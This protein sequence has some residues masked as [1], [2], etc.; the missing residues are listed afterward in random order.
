[1]AQPATATLFVQ[2]SDTTGGRLPGVSLSV[3]NQAT[4]VQRTATTTAGGAAV[5]PLLPAGDYVVQARLDGFRVLS[6]DVF[7]LE[8]GAAKT[9][10]LNLEPG[11]ITETVRV[12]ADRVQVRAG[13]GAVGEVFDSQVLTM[14]PVAS[15]DV[16]EYAWQAPGVAPPAPG[17]RLSGEG[18]TPL[19]AAGA[20]EASNNFLLDGVDNNDLFLNRVLVTPSLDAVQEFTLIS[21]TYDAQYGRSAGAQV[22]VVLK[23]G[24]D[25]TTGSL[26]AFGRDR[27]LQAR[28]PLDPQDQDE[29]YRRR[30][31]AGG[32][33]GGPIA[34]LKSFYFVSLQGTR[35]RSGDTRVA[36]VPGDAERAGDFS[37]LPTPIVDPATGQPFPGNRIPAS[38][39]DATG[40]RML[41]LF[42]RANRADASGNF[43]SSPIAPDDTWQFTGRFDRP[44]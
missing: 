10:N 12:T 42:P 2:V 37:A 29:P 36:N 27:A 13:S 25:R 30:V 31:Q 44:S 33:I 28:G 7:H 19:N 14:T 15:R 4:G 23:S 8:A 32:T 35:D 3:V 22:N 6:I 40:L 1:A 5:V 39:F 9:F 11:P 26:Y 21:N 24:S 38:R 16:G 20:R 41:D 17:S 18:G 34:P 43:V